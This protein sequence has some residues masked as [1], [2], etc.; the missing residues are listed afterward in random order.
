MLNKT[1]YYYSC[2]ITI[3]CVLVGKPIPSY[4]RNQDF[5]NLNFLAPES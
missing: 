2:I 3:S 1:Y 5:S 4:L